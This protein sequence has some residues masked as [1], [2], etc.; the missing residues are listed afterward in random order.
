MET[1]FCSSPQ[2]GLRKN[3]FPERLCCHTSPIRGD[4]AHTIKHNGNLCAQLQWS[5]QR[6]QLTQAQI[7]I[8][9]FLAESVYQSSSQP[10][11]YHMKQTERGSWV[12]V[13]VC[14]YSSMI[15]ES[16]LVC[17]CLLLLVVAAVLTIKLRRQKSKLMSTIK[18][19]HQKS[20]VSVDNEKR[21]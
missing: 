14:V 5:S 1:L 10:S 19:L 15:W 2:R 11:C 4:V 21:K 12:C 16:L 9:P 20:V 17:L 13:C 7:M 3:S 6:V 18:D 8:R